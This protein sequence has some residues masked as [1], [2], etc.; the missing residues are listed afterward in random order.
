[1]LAVVNRRLESRRMLWPRLPLHRGKAVEVD[2][3]EVVV[4]TSSTRASGQQ[5]GEEAAEPLT[6]VTAGSEDRPGWMG[7]SPKAS[8]LMS[9]PATEPRAAHWRQ[10]QSSIQSRRHSRQ[11]S[12]R[13]VSDEKERASWKKGRGGALEGGPGEHSEEV[14][15]IE[16]QNEEAQE[17]PEDALL[18]GGDTVA[19]QIEQQTR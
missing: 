18:H 19:I 4:V 9:R 13:R 12:Q 7:E 8:W 15:A 5:L 6:V 2:C 14:V 1:M 3:P 17:V 11:Q 10:A 16:V